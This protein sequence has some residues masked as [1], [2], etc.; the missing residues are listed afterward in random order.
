[1]LPPMTIT[2]TSMSGSPCADSLIP[3]LP[4]R[5]SVRTLPIVGDDRGPVLDDPRRGLHDRDEMA[6]TDTH[7]IAHWT[8]NRL[9]IDSTGLGWHDAYTS[10]A[11]ESSWSATLPALPH[12][13]LAY[14]VRRS[15]RIRRRVEGSAPEQAELLPAAVRHDPRRPPVDLAAR[16]RPRDPAGIPEAGDDR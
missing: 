2:G 12:Y 1:M 9:M 14:C 10:L 8:S 15:A 4:P 16:R 11:A 5:V 6:A 7:G 13:N 3:G